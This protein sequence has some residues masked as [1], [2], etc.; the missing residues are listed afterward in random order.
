MSDNGD[1]IETLVQAYLEGEMKPGDASTL[2]A[3]LKRE[4]ALGSYVLQELRFDGLLRSTLLEIGRTKRTFG[5]GV[6]V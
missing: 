5:D 4:P 6:R 1:R 2:L 3:R